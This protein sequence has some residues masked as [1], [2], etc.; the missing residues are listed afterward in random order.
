MPMAQMCDGIG[1]DKPRRY[2]ELGGSG[3][4]CAQ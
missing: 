4:V 2:R 3:S 1:G